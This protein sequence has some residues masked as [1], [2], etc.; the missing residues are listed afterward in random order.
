MTA[1]ADP[2]RFTAPAEARGERTLVRL[3]AEASAALPSRGQVAVVGRLN[4]A[5]FRT[6]VEP[7]GR[8]GH[9]I[10][11][12]DTPVT[13]GDEVA[14]EIAPVR[15]WPE[16]EV[17]ADLRAALDTAPDTADVWTGIT[18]M[19]RWEWVRWIGAT[20]SPATR[21]KRVEVTI[22]KMRG[23]KRRPCCFDLSSCTDPDLMRNGALI[24]PEAAASGSA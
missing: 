17:P 22:D 5:D 2:V 10:A 1:T 23:G 13:A 8:K 3:P 6:V 9:W 16:P 7:D 12:D 15:D 18:S 24:G 21:A 4:G 14:L 20:R 11:L 19:A